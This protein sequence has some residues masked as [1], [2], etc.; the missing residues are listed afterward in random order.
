MR[1][2]AF[3]EC[4]IDPKAEY[5]EGKIVRISLQWEDDV[6]EIAGN[7]YTDTPHEEQALRR[8]VT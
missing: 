2:L 4:R 7:V 3:V 1:Q 8:T 5:L 6:A